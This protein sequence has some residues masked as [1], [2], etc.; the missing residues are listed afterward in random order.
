MQVKTLLAG[1]VNSALHPSGVAESSTSVGWRKGG[2]VTSAGWQV[3][4]CDPTRH[5][6]C[7]SGL[8]MLYCELLYEHTSLSFT[9][10]YVLHF[11]VIGAISCFH[12]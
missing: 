10:L 4:L 8:A 1:V 6:S 12:R 2:N 5:V 9:L 11:A 7:R 3:T